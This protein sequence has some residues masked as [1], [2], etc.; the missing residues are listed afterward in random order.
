MKS[1]WVVL[2]AGLLLGGAAFSTPAASAPPNPGEVPLAKVNGE[3]ITGA[4]L[5]ADFTRRHG[6]HQKFLMGAS[7][8]RS[9]L[10][11]VIDDRL[12]VQEAYRLD[13]QDLE[14]VKKPAS[15][16]AQLK[17]AEYLVQNEIE[18]KSRPTE[19]DVRRAW[20][21][22]TTTLYL[23]RRI[24]VDSRPEADALASQLAAGGDFEKRARACSTDAS[25]ADGGQ[26][27]WIGWGTMDPAWEGVVFKMFPGET[28]PPFETAD[29][30]E[31]VQL[32]AAET[33]ERPEYAQ[34]APRIEGIL[35]KRWREANRRE[36]SDV[37]WAKYH[38]RQADIEL[39]PEGSHAALVKSPDA[40]IA[41]WDGGSLP[42]GQFVKGVDWTTMAGLSRA[43]VRSELAERLRDAVNADL[44]RREATARR[45]DE[46]PEVAA[47]VRRYREDRMLAV[48]YDQ[49]VLKDVTVSD[50]EVRQYFEA[51]Q[52]ELSTPGKRRVS[53][54]VVA[55]RGEVDAIRAQAQ[56]G[57]A[58]ADLVKAHSTDKGTAG[59]GGDLGWIASRDAT[60]EL[61]AVL[62]LEK[63]VV[64]EPIESRFGWHLFVVTAVAPPQAMDFDE[65]RG[66][67]RRKLLE[68]KQR[69]KRA[70]WV[71]RLRKSSEISV[72]DKAIQKFVQSNLNNS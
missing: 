66:E 19:Q 9:F 40:P 56:A 11:I 70:V 50:E 24:V 59:R 62:T 3:A 64:S 28:S 47:A 42:V 4:D 23:A 51:H 14:A 61:S 54:L 16:Y 71:A 60:G 38:V 29:G 44:V 17:A 55:T 6:G 36:L 10:D 1:P 43:R 52:K 5:Q 49:Y 26:I 63:G 58:F 7:E 65:A 13:L 46:V 20:E 67:I 39:S 37:L 57:T 31:I 21:E 69:E 25:G 30:W 53:H 34:A 12:L 18:R 32:G 35:K 33:V 15:E 22:R 27:D 8:V 72:S 48:L 68:K 2:G 41:T 45:L